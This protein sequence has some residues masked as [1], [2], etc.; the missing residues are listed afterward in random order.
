MGRPVEYQRTHQW[1]RHCGH[2]IAGG[3]VALSV[4]EAGCPRQR[5]LDEAELAEIDE[6]E[7]TVKRAA[8]QSCASANR[9]RRMKD[10]ARYA[11]ARPATGGFPFN[12][13]T[14]AEIEGEK[15]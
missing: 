14:I 9:L 7:D 3:S 2:W 11:P 10:A 6:R 4:H 8:W 1:C 5:D 13:R 15:P 12:R